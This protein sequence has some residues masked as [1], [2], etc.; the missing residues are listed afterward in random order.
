MG[1]PGRK[2]ALVI[3]TAASRRMS[4][5]GWIV[6]PGITGVAGLAAFAYRQAPTFW[7]TL[8]RDVQR[9]VLAPANRPDVRSWPNR[10][11]FAAWLG[12]S[13]VLLKIAGTP[14]LADPVS[15]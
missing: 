1:I 9:P 6:A 12:H 10:G 15:R 11:I 14:I 13:T 5:R 7:K 8:V 2:N 4:R 3:K